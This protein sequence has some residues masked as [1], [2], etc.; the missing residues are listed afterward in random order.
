MFDAIAL[1]SGLVGEFV[2]NELTKLGY[3]VHVIDLKIP[4]HVKNNPQVSFQEGDVFDLLSQMPEAKIAVNMLPGRI[5][6]QMRT[7]LI[8]GGIDV[9]DLA[10]TEQD[11]SQ[12]NSLAKENSATMIWDVGIAPGLSNMIIKKEFGE[13]NNILSATIKVGGNPQSPDDTWS[14]MAPFSPSDVIEEYTRPARILVDGE[15]KTVPAL[16]EKH[17][18]DV[19]GFGKM[20]AFLTDGLRSLLVSNLS[21]NMKEYTVRW[22]GHIQRYINERESGE[23]DIQS[24]TSE[25]RYDDEVDEFTWMEVIAESLDGSKMKWQVQDHGS[26]DGH[27]MARATGLVTVCCV[28]EW[29][30]DPDMLPSG[31]H[32]PEALSSDVVRRILSRM[33]QDG[34]DIEG[35]IISGL[36]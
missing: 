8:E 15:I 28:E 3:Q 36:D 34:V 33:A 14:Y 9:V 24:L 31:V 16:T 2:I 22:P 25:W 12:H 26:H 19:D 35:P 6:E 13:D 5:G 7:L 18:I 17:F 11:P 1:G 27:S 29:I 32:P 23:L 20:E 21:K 10:F 4:D 30:M